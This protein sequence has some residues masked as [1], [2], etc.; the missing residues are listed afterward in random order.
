MDRGAWWVTAHSVSKSRDTTEQARTHI[1]ASSI[2]SIAVTLLDGGGGGESKQEKDRE[3][4]WNLLG[5]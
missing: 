2:P 3:H 4:P 5:S 1:F